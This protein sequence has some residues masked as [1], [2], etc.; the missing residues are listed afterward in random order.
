MVDRR[1]IE[2]IGNRRHRYGN[3]RY[4]KGQFRSP[5]DPFGAV[6][7]VVACLTSIERQHDGCVTALIFV[8]NDRNAII[9]LKTMG[10]EL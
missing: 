2:H 7:D 1:R 10:L 5:V 4:P 3:L 8:Q 6:G 9:L